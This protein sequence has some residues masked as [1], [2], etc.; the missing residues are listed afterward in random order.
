MAA[1]RIT[2]YGTRNCPN[3]RLAR[4]YLQGLG[5]R[6]REFDVNRDRRAQK[7]LARLGTR[8]VPV[9]LVGDRRVDGFDRARLDR[10]L[11]PQATR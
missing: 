5:L 10:L 2:L 11:K 3:C 7:D 1:P 6:F 4:R 8:S 9:I